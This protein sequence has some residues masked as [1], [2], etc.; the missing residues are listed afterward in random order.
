L[1]VKPAGLGSSIGISRVTDDDDLSQAVTHALRYD[2]SVIVEQ[3]VIG[4]ELECAVLGG[5]SPEASVV[6]EVT[7]SGGW[8]D[9]EQKY[10]ADEDPMIVPAAVPEHVAQQVRDLSV[11]A[12][13]AAGCWG[14]ARVDF[15]YDDI[16]DAVYVNEINTMPGFT[17]YSMYPKVWAAAGMSYV[18][19]VDR[20]VDLA[21]ERHALRGRRSLT[22]VPG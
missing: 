14:L 17:E 4:R 16:D 3:G 22:A 11:R 8:F 21:F 20:L 15:L 5:F 6:G 19:L 18:D 1:F 9:Y 2:S 13:L 12:F 10:F 7:V